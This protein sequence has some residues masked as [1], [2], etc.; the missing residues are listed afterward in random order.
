MLVI[1][2]SGSFGSPEVNFRILGQSTYSGLSQQYTKSWTAPTYSNDFSCDSNNSTSS[3]I[4]QNYLAGDFNGDGLSDV[5]AINKPYSERNCYPVLSQP[6]EPCGFDPY[7]AQTQDSIPIIEKKPDTLIGPQQENSAQIIEPIDGCC[8][9]ETYTNSISRANFINLKRDITSGFANSA[10][11]MYPQVK[12]NDKLITADV[13]GDGK[14]NIIHVT[15]GQLMVY[16]L[17]QN[18]YLTKL[19]TKSDSDISTTHP[20]LLGDYN[21]DGKTDIL[22]PRGDDTT[23]FRLLLSTGESF[24]AS[25]STYPFRYR[26]TNFSSSGTLSGYNLVPTDINGD[27]RTDIID[28]KTTTYNNSSN[29]TQNL[30]VYKNTFTT[31]YYGRPKFSS[32]V[33]SSQT[34]DLKHFPIP[35]FLSSKDGNNN[36]DFAAISDN[37]ITS[38]SFSKDNREDMLLRGI[39]NNGVYQSINY[40]DLGVVP[41]GSYNPNYQSSLSETY[42]YI[43]IEQARGFKIVEEIEQSGT[44]LITK[45]KNFSYYDAISH[46]QGLG[47]SG[48]KGVSSTNWYTNIS[49]RIYNVSKFDP[50]QRAVLTTDYTTDSYVNFTSSPSGYITKTEHQYDYNIDTDKVIT[51]NKTSASTINELEGTVIT[52]NYYYD[53]YNNQEEIVTNYPG[54]TEKRIQVEY[55]NNP[56]GTPYYI[57]IPKKRT[58]I[59]T[60]DGNSYTSQEEYTYSSLLVSEKKTKGNSTGYIV[61]D[62]T[63]DTY[64]N[65]ISKTTTPPGESSKQVNFEY[66]N[67]G[68]FLLKETDSEGLETEYEYSSTSGMVRTTTDPFGF[69]TEFEYDSW[70]RPLKITDHLGNEVN[71]TYNKVNNRYTVTTYSDD[72]TGTTSVYDK[73]YRVVQEKEKNLLGD[74]VSVDYEYDHLNR[75]KRQSE[76]HIGGSASQWNT[77]DYDKY[78]RPEQKT[79]YTGK[80]VSFTYNGLETT[81]DDGTKQEIITKDAL[82]N[83]VEKTDPGGT[84]QYTYFGNGNLKQANYG[85]NSLLIEQDG[86]GQKT[87]LTDPSAGIYTYE[88]NGFGEVVR[89][90]NPKGETNFEYDSGG[91]VLTKEISG[92]NTDMEINY[93]YNSSTKLLS[94][95]FMTDGSGNTSDYNYTYDTNHRLLKEKETTDFA[96]FE[97]TYTYNTL[98]QVLTEEYSAKD[99]LSSKTSTKKIK[100]TYQN[101]GIIKITDNSSNSVIWELE[102][103]NARGQTLQTS[104]GNGI[105]KTSSYD[106]LGFVEDIES[107]KEESSGNNI[108]L[109]HLEFDFNS[110]RG[111]L[112]S[113]QNSLFNW[114]ETFAYDNLD[115]LT[116]FDDNTGNGSQSYD[117]KGRINLNSKLGNYGYTGNSYQQTSL[118]FN[119]Q[120]EDYFQNLSTQSISYNVFKQPVEIHEHGKDKASFNYNAFEERS[121]MFYGGTQNDPN[122]RRYRK[123][124]SSNGRMEI[125][126]DSDNNETTFVN[127]IGGDAYSAPVIWHSKQGTSTNNNFYYL[128]RDYLGSILGITDADGNFKE[129]RHFDAWG[130]IIK[131]EDGNGNAISSFDILDRGYTGHEHLLGVGIVHMNGRLYDP[132]LH[133]FLSPDN[134]VQNPFNSQNFNRY[135]YVLHNPLS[136]IDPSGELSLKGFVR[137]FYK[138]VAYAVAA[139]LIATVVFAAVAVAQVAFLLAIPTLAAGGYLAYKVATLADDKI[140]NWIDNIPE[141]ENAIYSPPNLIPYVKN[142]NFNLK[143][144]E[145]F[146]RIYLPEEIFSLRTLN[147]NSL[148]P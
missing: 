34:G 26:Q 2:N 39:S 40:N 7:L 112:D 74:W 145:K 105:I 91:R 76:P 33:S 124:Y 134:Y 73:L 50:H 18:N 115:R 20:L 83:I 66:D 143:I 4:P 75:I 27:G 136:Y 126:F 57:G 65:I 71:Y 8:R 85:S 113:R 67:S 24:V 62:Y 123:H 119:N 139:V 114:S 107:I 89:E 146:F 104:V 98:G 133:R 131:L 35:I 92:E 97:T 94:N 96:E 144:E 41:S 29:G 87:K 120:G 129:K 51:A 132:V 121:D 44:G 101:G 52:E 102:E 13:N 21:G 16:G 55:N 109:M 19:F 49:D 125:K 11:T 70:F 9:C 31:D 63:Y 25:T 148:K 77:T 100:N 5:I 45:K 54:N 53:Q 142:N 61:E 28:Y 118:S 6:G 99:Y 15:N 38:F 122:Q 43:N 32:S 64:G 68:R 93:T 23:S 79:S 111:L 130:E 137:A 127:Y 48:F 22:I 42:P 147:T 72:G 1:Q 110:Q 135:G 86:W 12:S 36:L 10:G 69:V 46:L 103:L 60:I 58:T 47:F 88:Y 141:T 78:G 37:R 59:S 116:G 17:N 84:I 106:N 82:G 30:T 81:I 138:I 90:T 128:H 140:N 14:T 3:R 80:T 56:S 108:S 95:I 117:Q